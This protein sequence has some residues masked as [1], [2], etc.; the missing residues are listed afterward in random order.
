MLIWDDALDLAKWKAKDSTTETETYLKLLMNMG[1]KEILA[2]FRRNQTVKTKTSLTVADQ[3]SYTTP[4]DFLMPK[5]VK[6]KVGSTWYPVTIIDSEEEWDELTSTSLTSTYPSAVFFRFR[7]GVGGTEMLLHPTPSAATTTI[8]MSYEATDRDLGQAKITTGT[9][10]VTL[11]D[12]TVTLTGASALADS[13]VGRYFKVDS[14]LGDGLWYGIASRTN[15]TTFELDL[16]YAGASQSGQ[17]FVIAEAFGLPEEMQVLPVYY[18][19]WNFWSQREHKEETERYF[20]LWRD[21][22][23]RAQTRYGV[24]RVGNKQVRARGT[25]KA[26]FGIY[27]GHFPTS[28]S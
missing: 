22:W 17:D 5:K 8:E 16:P 12:A 19:L 27:P 21:G 11:G 14:A 3:Q 20:N 10:E 6:A 15:V 28:V 24:K 13:I 23:K 26:R 4:P 2:E 7:F 1:Y 25:V 9:T 18:A